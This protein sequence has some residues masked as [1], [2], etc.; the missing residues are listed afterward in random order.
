MP[1]DR[2]PVTAVLIVRAWVEP[3]PT[4]PLRIVVTALGDLGGDENPVRTHATSAD[5]VCL[6]VRHWLEG[7]VRSGPLEA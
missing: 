7:V 3:H 6:L 1:D 2:A 4:V 5:E